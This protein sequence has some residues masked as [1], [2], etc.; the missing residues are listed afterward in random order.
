[1]AQRAEPTG[2]EALLWASD[3]LFAARIAADGTVI[4]A[5]AA[6]TRWV[7]GDAAGMD[8]RSLA[9]ARHRD[10]L[11]GL[12]EEAGDSWSRAQLGFEAP[13]PQAADD[14]YVL[15][16]R[17]G[18]EVLLVAEPAQAERERLVEQVLELNED[19]IAAQRTANRRQR[20]LVRAQAEAEAAEDR[21]RRLES[22]MLAGLTAPDL[23]AVLDAL[24][25]VAREVLGADWAAVSLRDE[26]TQRLTV[27]A[28]TG[29]G[30]GAEPMRVALVLDGTMIGALEVASP[31]AFAE[32]DHGLLE[33]VAE[34][35]ALAIGHAR[36]RERERAIAEALQRSVLPHSLPHV[37]AVGLRA[38]YL[39]QL[40]GVGVGGDFYDAVALGDGRVALSIG[41]VAGKGLGAASTMGRVCHALRAYALE[42]TEPGEALGRLDRLMVEEGYQMATALQLVLDPATGTIV[43]ANAGHPPALRVRADG[44]T[45]FI[46]GALGPPLGAGVS[47]RAQASARLE[48]GERLLIYTDGLIERRELSIDVGLD[49][50]ARAAVECASLDELVETMRGDRAFEDDVAVLSVTLRA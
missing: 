13:A 1:M 9:T 43:F 40:D 2:L 23:P 45:E 8:A 15:V 39:P 37:E 49:Q 18:A 47:T 6:L 4:A 7:G 25:G 20:A 3:T 42:A 21:V 34:R 11:A 14:R 10:L 44:S 35:A 19:L 26:R 46:E 30:T 36:L 28:S 38:A 12:V 32:G 24:L 50:L 22:I 33:R 17:A 41:D 29:P 16:R 5:N 48:P 31:D 27:A